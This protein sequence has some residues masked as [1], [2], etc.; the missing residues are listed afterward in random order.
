[1]MKTIIMGQACFVIGLVSMVPHSLQAQ[2]KFE[3]SVGADLVS[4]YIWRGQ[5]CGGVS[6]QPTIS[7][8][9]S[10]FS[11]TAWGSTGFESKDVKELD[12]TLGY[13]TGGFSVSVTDYYFKANDPYINEKYFNYSAHSTAHVYE[14]TIGYDFGPVALC[15]NTNFAGNDYAK[16]D[17]GRA[18]SSYF[19]VSA[20]F[21]LGDIDFTAEIGGT[22]WE[23][24][25]TAGSDKFSIINI[26]LAANKAI[27]ITQKFDIPVFGKVIFNP[28]TEDAYFV[29]GLNL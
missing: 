8:S 27:K 6:V 12:F 2:E 23:G 15:W 5:D 24:A 22:P 11:L 9:K 21:K 25:Y 18:Y 19:E 20:P 14:A 13:T 10:G 3:A 4:K 16:Q 7:I 28:R 17:G 29:F 26:G 1:M